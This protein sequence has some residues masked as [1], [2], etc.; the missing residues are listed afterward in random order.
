MIISSRHDIRLQCL[1]Y[2]AVLCVQKKA[3]S[4]QTDS[5]RHCVPVV[6]HSVFDDMKYRVTCL[7]HR[8]RCIP[9]VMVSST[10]SILNTKHHRAVDV[11]Y[12]RRVL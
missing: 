10:S 11:T 8:R 4:R 9:D 5:R 6:N 3:T 12:R 2:N 7:R 1:Q